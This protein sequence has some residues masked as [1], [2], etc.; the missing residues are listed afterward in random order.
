M[1]RPWPLGAC[2]P[3]CSPGVFC[4]RCPCPFGVCSPVCPLGVLCRMCG[5]LGHLASVH[6][7]A[8]SVCGVCCVLGHLALVHWCARS[9]CC[10][11]SAVSLAT[12]LLFT[13]VHCPW[14]LSFCSPVCPLGVFCCVCGVLG[15]LGPVHWCAYSVCCI[16][17][18]V[19]LAT[20]LLFTDV[21]VRCV[22]CAVSLATWLL[23]TGVPARCA[24]LRV[25]C[26]WPLGSCPP[27]CPLSVLCCV[28][29]VLG[30]LAPL[31]RCASPVCCVCGVLGHLA[32]VHWRAACCVV[33][34][35][36]LAPWLVCVRGLC[37]LLC[38]ATRCAFLCLPWL[39]CAPGVLVRPMPHALLK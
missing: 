14:Q 36:S 5:V 15:H 13:G 12:W 23:F 35:V 38:G 39:L 16:A 10:V 37:V 3:L 30:H 33:Y 19:S 26:R 7:C 21:P 34:V 8:R 17:C 31:H 25:R 2:S 1:R 27:V 6:R 11:A 29:G 18:A 20:W 24:V 28:C 4:V 32:L 22:V 9:V